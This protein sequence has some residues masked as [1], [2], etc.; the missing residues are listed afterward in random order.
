[1]KYFF[2]VCSFVLFFSLIS[3]SY[4]LYWFTGAGIRKPAQQI[5]TLYNKTHKN[6]VVIISGG[7]GQVLNEMIEAKKGDIYTLVD[8]IFLKRAVRQNVVVKYKK[9]LK[10][11][12]VFILSATGAKKIKNFYDLSKKGIKIAGGNPKAM[13]LGKTFSEIMKK[14]PKNLSDKMNSNITLRC[15]NVFQILGYAKE[16]SVD[17][18]IVLDRA[19][20]KKTGLRYIAIPKKYNVHRYGY[21]ALVSFSKHRREANKLFDFILSH[22]N[23]YSRYGFEIVGGR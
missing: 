13:C 20:I 14:L 4:T 9:I 11:T 7:S 17:A 12:P 19:L 23:Y 10:L 18:G 2:M 21:L 3:H 1:M 8:S 5:A 16:N 15:L 22:K 6:K